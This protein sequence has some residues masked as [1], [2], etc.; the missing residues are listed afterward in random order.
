MKIIIF[1]Y[2]LILLLAEALVVPYS[3]QIFR[4][5]GG[6]LPPL[7]PPLEPL[8]AITKRVDEFAAQLV[9]E[10][11]KIKVEAKLTIAKRAASLWSENS[12]LL[13]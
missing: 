9:A 6:M 8:L 7:P 10:V 12:T 4:G 5:F 13:A 2:Y 3:L 1:Y 11:E